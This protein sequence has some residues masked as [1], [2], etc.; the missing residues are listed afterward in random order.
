MSWLWHQIVLWFQTEYIP[1]S[2]PFYDGQTWGNVFVAPVAFALGW[3]W[4][5]SKFWPLRPLEHGLAKTHEV[6]TTVHEHV[7]TMHKK[8]DDLHEKHDAL[9]QRV[10]EL[11]EKLDRVLNA[12][13]GHIGPPNQHTI[14]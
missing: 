10:E 4:T 3:L 11:H 14:P 8:H 2:G 9:T 6:L 7:T 5:K 1:K 12:S 13:G